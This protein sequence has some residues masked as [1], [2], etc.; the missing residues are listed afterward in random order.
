MVA[1]REDE[2]QNLALIGKA[3]RGSKKQDSRRVIR[4]RRKNLVLQI[5]ERKT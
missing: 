2:I 1:A 4:A 5:K 3:R